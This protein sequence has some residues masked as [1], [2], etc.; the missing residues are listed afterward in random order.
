MPHCCRSDSKLM[1]LDQQLI[2]NWK[3]GIFPADFTSPPEKNT[4]T[5]GSSHSSC[6]IGKMF[7]SEKKTTTPFYQF[8]NHH[9]RTFQEKNK[10]RF[11][12]TDVN[13]DSYID[14]LFELSWPLNKSV[15]IAPCAFCTLFCGRHWRSFFVATRFGVV[16]FEP[17]ISSVL[18]QFPHNANLYRFGS[19][20]H[21][22]CLKRAAYLWPC[23]RTKSTMLNAIF[24]LCTVAVHFV[25]SSSQRRYLHWG[26]IDKIDHQHARSHSTWKLKTP[27]NDDDKK[28]VW[29][30]NQKK[31]HPQNNLKTKDIEFIMNSLWSLQPMQICGVFFC[32]VARWFFQGHLI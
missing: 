31:K 10:C 17:K 2:R 27:I 28:E 5:F 19:F 7:V 4:Q 24:L 32:F 26:D 6:R 25:N 12:L 20:C 11:W 23:K 15:C 3:N 30:K 13:C 21:C 8:W 18:Y 16:L 22:T 14:R 9:Q 29:V 1:A